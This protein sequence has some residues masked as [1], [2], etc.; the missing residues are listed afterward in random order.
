[1]LLFGI[2]TQKTDFGYYYQDYQEPS[3]VSRIILAR[4]EEREV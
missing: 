3:L 4:I 2:N 1:M